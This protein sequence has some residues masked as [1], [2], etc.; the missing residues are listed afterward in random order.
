YRGLVGRG[1]MVYKVAPVNDPKKP[2][3]YK[4]GWPVVVR[5]LEADT[6]K[7]LRNRLP[8]WLHE[9]LPEV[10]SSM[11]RTAE[12]LKLPRVELLK[13]DTIKDFEDR[14]LHAL[15]M[16]LYG[17]LWEVGNVD[18]FMDVWVHCLECKS[19]PQHS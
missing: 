15:V 5:K 16:K 19:P 4:V 10:V 18:A 8:E 17:K 6:I 3:A 2:L 11:T 7:R 13:V 9:H 12:Q 14:V 1:T